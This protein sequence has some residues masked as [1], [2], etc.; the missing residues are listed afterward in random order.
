MTKLLLPNSVRTIG[1]SAFLECSSLAVIRL[2]KNRNLAMGRQG[3]Y[4]FD[5]CIG[6]TKINV[7]RIALTVWPRHLEQFND[8][9]LFSHMGLIQVVRNTCAFSFLR[10][11]APQLFEDRGSHIAMPV[12]QQGW[13]RQL[14]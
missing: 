12:P 10:Q 11:N 7:P 6:L 3:R 8:D 2:P 1:Y 14:V 4:M 9:G 5:G 13:K